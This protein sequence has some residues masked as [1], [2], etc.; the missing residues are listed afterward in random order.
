[1][2]RNTIAAIFLFV[3]LPA[4]LNGQEQKLRERAADAFEEAETGTLTLR[5]FNALNGA[6]I[7]GGEVTIGNIGVV[8]TDFE[9]KAPFPAPEEDGTVPVKFSAQGYITSEFNIE[10]MNNSLYFNRYSI[11]PVMDLRFLR[12]VLDWGEEPLDLDL[13][14]V[15]DDGYHISYRDT[16]T[17][18][19]GT[20]ALDRDDRDGYGPETITVEEISAAARYHCHILDYSN[21]GSHDSN[22]LA[23]SRATVKVYG[24]GRLLHVF[25]VPRAGS[26]TLWR[27]FDIVGGIVHETGEMAP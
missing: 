22:G 2:M 13:H 4:L 24:E 27:V 1:M 23:R 5:F 11:S 14:F 18:D 3:A 17:L 8:V 25:G 20:G 26:G 9:G 6:P 10:I 7:K 21:R 16:K 19:D 15:K 12:V